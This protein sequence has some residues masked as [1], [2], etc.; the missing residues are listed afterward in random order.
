M[1]RIETIWGG[2]NRGYEGGRMSCRRS[3]GRDVRESVWSVAFL[4]GI[5]GVSLVDGASEVD[6]EMS[7]VRGSEN[8]TGISSLR[9]ES[10]VVLVMNSG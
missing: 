4:V 7:T 9:I 6:S 1:A 3:E 10:D 5:T 2:V 8:S